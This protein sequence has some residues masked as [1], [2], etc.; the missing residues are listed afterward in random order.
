MKK[1]ASQ[2]PNPALNILQEAYHSFLTHE[3]EKINENSQKH[4]E[5]EKVRLSFVEK[6]EV[7]EED[8]EDY[9]FEFSELDI[10]ALKKENKAD[11][12]AEIALHLI[13][14]KVLH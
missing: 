7:D 12:I 10:A 3:E 8:D 1:K 5:N 13:F 14:K 4:T 11:K 2:K 6:N 9:E